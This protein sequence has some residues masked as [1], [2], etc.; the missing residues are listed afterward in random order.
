MP[1]KN[2]DNIA[3]FE[4]Y[5]NK[6]LKASNYELKKNNP[7]RSAKLRY[8][9][10]SDNKFIYPENFIEKFNFYLKLETINV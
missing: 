6:I 3:L 7:S 8:A 4:K 1:E 2:S 10:R 5:K 9:I